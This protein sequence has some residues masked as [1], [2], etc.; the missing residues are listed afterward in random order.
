MSLS[1]VHLLHVLPL[2]R[3]TFATFHPHECLQ[4]NAKARRGSLVHD[5]EQLVPIKWNSLRAVKPLAY[6]QRLFVVE[7]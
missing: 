4:L 3:R 1:E 6:F 5:A 7:Q 2:I